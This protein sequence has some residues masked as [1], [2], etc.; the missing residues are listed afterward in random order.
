MDQNPWK[1]K[2]SKELFSMRDGKIATRQTLCYYIEADKYTVRSRFAYTPSK[3]PMSE[4]KYCGIYL[5]CFVAERL[6]YRVFKNVKQMP[7]GNIGYDFICGK[8][9]KIDV[10]SSC[11]TKQNYWGFNIRHNKIADFFLCIAFDDREKLNPLHMWLIPSD[12]VNGFSHIGISEST[13][14]KWK[15]W[16]HPIAEVISCCNQMKGE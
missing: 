9:Y 15:Q 2:R 6:L 4:N 14:D 12:D 11:R 10:K 8:N 16:E 1:T 5:G 3:N 13:I 7:H